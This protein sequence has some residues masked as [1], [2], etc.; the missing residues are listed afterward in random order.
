LSAARPQS[1]PG[2]RIDPPVSEPSDSGAKPAATAAAEP[3]LEPPGTR[4]SS[5]G[6][7]VTW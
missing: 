4:V 3:P 2:W 6:F 5:Q 1:A 7:F